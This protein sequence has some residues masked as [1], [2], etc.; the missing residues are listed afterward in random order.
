MVKKE[1]E[2][3]LISATHIIHKHEGSNN[4]KKKGRVGTSRK[5]NG[6]MALK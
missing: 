1:R 2:A 6:T 3:E 4:A 5:K